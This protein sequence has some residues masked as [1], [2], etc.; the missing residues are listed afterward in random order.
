MQLIYVNFYSFAISQQMP[1]TIVE[2]A[3]QLCTRVAQPQW[4]QMPA[5]AEVS[6]Q[7]EIHQ[8]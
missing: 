8:E 1:L 5:G 2:V 4:W 3:T 7:T 6:G